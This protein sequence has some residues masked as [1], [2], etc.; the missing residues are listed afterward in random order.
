MLDTHTS[1]KTQVL[2]V[3]FPNGAWRALIAALLWEIVDSVPPGTILLRIK[4]WFISF[5]ITIEEFAQCVTL[6]FGAR[7]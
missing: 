6:V 4:K 7:P 5:D 3:L 1:G 2:E